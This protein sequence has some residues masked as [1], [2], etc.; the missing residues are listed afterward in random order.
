MIEKDTLKRTDRMMI[1]NKNKKI[2][3]NKTYINNQ[4]SSNKENI[5]LLKNI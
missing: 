4:I 5:I 2:K 3:Q 1:K